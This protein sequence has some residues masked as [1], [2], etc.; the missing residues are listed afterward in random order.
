MINLKRI[1]NFLLEIIF[2]YRITKF[3]PERLAIIKAKEHFKNK[4]I[5]AC[6]IG[7]FKGYHAYQILKHLYIEKLYLIDPYVKYEDYKNDKSYRNILKAKQKAKK[8]L[9]PYKD[10]IIWI[11][12]FSHDA[13]KEINE[14]IDF[15]YIDGNHFHPYVDNDIKNYY[16]LVNKGGIISGHDYSNSW[17]DVVNA[18]NKFFNKKRIFFGEGTDWLVFK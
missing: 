9:E 16:P 13:I 15:L 14:K 10:K 12:K 1:P 3:F 5:I 4:E 8:L 6:E 7:V 11:E 17:Q 18:V 2:G